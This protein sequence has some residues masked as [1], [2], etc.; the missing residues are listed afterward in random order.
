MIDISKEPNKLAPPV[1]IT[2]V[3]LS[4]ESL[5]FASAA[6]LPLQVVGIIGL[7]S[8]AL[9]SAFLLTAC[10]NPNGAWDCM[11]DSSLICKDKK[12]NG[13]QRYCKWC[14]KFKPDR[15]HHCKVS[16]FYYR[17]I[18]TQND[19]I[20]IN[21]LDFALTLFDSCLTLGNPSQQMQETTFLQTEPSRRG[22]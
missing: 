3:V 20:N 10:T 19:V 22:H 4:Q 7:L 6:G 9:F 16:I 5:F 1:W 15:C 13:E 8:V 2:F 18:F 14:S 17:R 11:S 12:R 21:H